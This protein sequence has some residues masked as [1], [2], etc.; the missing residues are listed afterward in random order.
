MS[1]KSNLTYE[2][3]LVCEKQAAVKAQQLPKELI[4]PVLRMI[5]Q[6]SRAKPLSVFFFTFINTIAMVVHCQAC[7][8]ICFLMAHA[9]VLYEIDLALMCFLMRPML[10]KC[11]FDFMFSW[12]FFILDIFHYV[13]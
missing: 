9:V 13:H 10:D 11:E 2:E 5:Q 12:S 3:A 1:G 8:T 4:A 7:D 6:Y